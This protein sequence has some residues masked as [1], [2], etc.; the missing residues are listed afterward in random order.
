MFGWFFNDALIPK[1]NSGK[2]VPMAIKIKP[3]NIGG[4]N[5]SIA[6]RFKQ[7]GTGK[8]LRNKQGRRH[9][10]TKKSGKK[11]RELA[12]PVSVSESFVKK[13]KRLI[14]GL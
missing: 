12:R 9:I 14:R 4:T 10:M 6:K 2:E 11:K 13:F 8:L 5:K 3:I 1:T 7:T